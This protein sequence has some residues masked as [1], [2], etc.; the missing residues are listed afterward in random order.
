MQQNTELIAR[1]LSLICH[2]ST[3][4]C[5]DIAPPCGLV[6]PS[7]VVHAVSTDKRPTGV[8]MWPR[9]AEK[10]ECRTFSD[11]VVNH[12]ACSRMGSLSRWHPSAWLWLYLS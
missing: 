11:H 9:A 5:G 10:G 7:G 4:T 3:L 12:E 8:V 6:Q 2:V 1:S